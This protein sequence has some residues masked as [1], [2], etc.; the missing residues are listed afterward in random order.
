MKKT[1]RNIVGGVLI[2]AAALLPAQKADAGGIQV[3]PHFSVTSPLVTLYN[4]SGAGAT[5]GYDLELDTIFNSNANAPPA[6]DFYSIVPGHNLSEDVR[7]LSSNTPFNT[8]MTG[9][10]ITSTI[11]GDLTFGMLDESDY[12]GKPILADVY[13]NGQLV[14]GNLD[15]RNYYLNG[16]SVPLTLGN[17][18]DFYN[19]NVKFT[20]EPTTA[21]TLALG[22][23]ALRKRKK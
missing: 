1:L 12:D 20:P 9:R 17:D 11:Q 19:V 10:G 16:T 4:V 5:D 2:G 18:S 8:L 14:L 15:V 6:V 21:L 3:V 22:A 7:D 23:A 13:K